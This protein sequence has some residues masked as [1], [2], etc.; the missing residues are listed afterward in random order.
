MRALLVTSLFL[1]TAA[2]AGCASKLPDSA[3]PGTGTPASG[4]QTL[5]APIHASE[6]VTGSFSGGNFA[7]GTPLDQGICS[8]AP[9][10]KCF[11]YPFSVN[12]TGGA[13]TTAV[14]TWTSQSSD[15]D[16]YVV[17]GTTI[18]SNDGINSVGGTNPSAYVPVTSQT[19]HAALPT[20]Q[21]EFLVVAWSV[22]QDTYT[23]DGN[24]TA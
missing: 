2:F 7:A 14:L 6:A 11:H 1:F 9:A 3:L 13:N 21:Y 16:L 10:A 18:V 5:P 24:F 12:A 15:F 22:A 23:L 19:L 20:G 8:P 17:Q 4:N